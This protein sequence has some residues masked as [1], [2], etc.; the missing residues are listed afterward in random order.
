[1]SLVSYGLF[2]LLFGRRKMTPLIMEIL[3]LEKQFDITLMLPPYRFDS[4]EHLNMETDAHCE[5]CNRLLGV[6]IPVLTD[7]EGH[8]ICI[9]C[10][11]N[12]VYGVNYSTYVWFQN[13]N[14]DMRDDVH[15]NWVKHKTNHI[16]EFTLWINNQPKL[17]N[18]MFMF[19]DSVLPKTA[20][21]ITSHY[22][23]Q[24][25][26]KKALNVWLTQI[27]INTNDCIFRTLDT[28]PNF[29]GMHED[30]MLIYNNPN[31]KHSSRHGGPLKM[32]YNDFS[33]VLGEDIYG[34][35]TAINTSLITNEVLDETY[36]D[37][38]PKYMCE[39]QL[40]K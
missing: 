25:L 21:D 8:S 14:L 12:H 5:I 27:G 36:L 6:S 29:N 32:T 20:S 22:L 18:E 39:E 23:P 2:Y 40:W 16:Y 4:E 19:L 31:K 1:M 35:I 24:H 33:K 15:M 37:L 26:D 10:Y 7:S 28:F 3:E 17:K 30:I 38:S 13:L 11:N 9:D 34:T